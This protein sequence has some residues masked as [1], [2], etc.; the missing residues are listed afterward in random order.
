MSMSRDGTNLKMCPLDDVHIKRLLG[1][2]KIKIKLVP[3]MGESPFDQI[4]QLLD[5]KSEVPNLIRVF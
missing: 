5:Q 3:Q 2:T 1:E 4:I